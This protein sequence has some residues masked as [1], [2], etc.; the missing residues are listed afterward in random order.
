MEEH[1][2]NS[3]LRNAQFFL[4]IVTGSN[5]QHLFRNQEQCAPDPIIIGKDIEKYRINFS[6]HYFKYDNSALQQVAPK[7]FYK[8]KNK[9]V[10]KFIGKKLTFAIDPKGYYTLNNVNGFI[11]DTENLSAEYLLALLNSQAIQY[12]YEKSFFTVKVLRGNLEKL[13]LI[14]VP[15]AD[16]KTVSK[17]AS[18][19]STSDSPTSIAQYSQQI[20]DI[21]FSAYKISDREINNYIERPDDE[22]SIDERRLNSQ[23]INRLNN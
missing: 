6:G 3:L 8:T 5:E 16:M 12:Y 4:G 7:Y 9:I 19:A 22:E 1:G 18:E 13:P 21:F 17:L 14:M 2:T 15:K 20:D 10:Y 11:P 23:I